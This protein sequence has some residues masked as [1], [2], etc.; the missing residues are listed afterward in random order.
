MLACMHVYE[1]ERVY[2]RVCPLVYALHMCLFTCLFMCI[3]NARAIQG[4]YTRWNAWTP[5]S[6][7]FVSRNTN[8]HPTHPC[9]P[10]TPVP[11]FLYLQHQLPDTPVG[12]KSSRHSRCLSDSFTRLHSWPDVSGTVGGPDKG[13]LDN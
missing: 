2:V 1:R 12:K 7:P 4:P 5:L 10:P 3:Y 8:E 11:L 13:G 6:F 9:N